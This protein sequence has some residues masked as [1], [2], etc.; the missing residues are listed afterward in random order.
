MED[1]II[2]ARVDKMGGVRI[3]QRKEEVSNDAVEGKKQNK[4]V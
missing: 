1:I 4:E 2:K 3:G